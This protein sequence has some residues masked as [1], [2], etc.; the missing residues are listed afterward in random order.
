MLENLRKDTD[1]QS[2][3]KKETSRVPALMI[4]IVKKDLGPMWHWLPDKSLSYDP[5]VLSK[6]KKKVGQ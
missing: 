1:F 6:P 2:F 3:V 4:E 5:N